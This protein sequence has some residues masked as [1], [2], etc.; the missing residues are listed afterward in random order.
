MKSVR[1]FIFHGLLFIVLSILTQVGGII[2][3]LS[4]VLAKRWSKTFTGKRL[5]IFLS[6]YLICAYVILP[7]TAPIFGRHKI[8]DLSGFKC[9]NVASS[10]L[11]RDYV[12]TK[13]L[14]VLKQIKHP[15]TIH[16]LDANFPFLNG[17]PLLPHLS[18][19]D[20]NKIDLSFIY[21]NHEGQ[22]VNVIKSR[23]GYGVFEEPLAW[24]ENQTL[25]CKNLGYFQYD[26]PKYLSFGNKNPQLEIS[27][28]ETRAL[29]S[30]LLA[31]PLVEKVF[32]EPHLVKRLDLT[33][34]KI[35]FHGCRAVR[36]DDHIH[37]QVYR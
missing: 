10:L 35:R 21:K 32:I 33:H 37:F 9:A 3:L 29:I 25:I 30:Q 24:E 36:H 34:P 2:Y 1:N 7:F 6:L 8:Q 19:N 28:R 11:N 31:N 15:N 4:I 18:H 14:K 13:M 20:G 17:F 27:K 12:S 26:Y 16:Y 22:A 23:S 5:L